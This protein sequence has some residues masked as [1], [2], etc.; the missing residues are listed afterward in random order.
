MATYDQIFREEMQPAL[1]FLLEDA[2]R[3]I[4]ELDIIAS[5]ELIESLTAYFDDNLDIVFDF[6]T[7]GV[8]QDVGLRGFRN[9]VSGFRPIAP[10]RDTT[11][12]DPFAA[13][14]FVTSTPNVAGRG[15]V[16]V[17]ARNLIQWDY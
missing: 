6:A 1:D 11:P 7:Q 17:N 8:I 13:G 4:I 9:P 10:F 16:I 15:E 2:E 12:A 3:M 14:A 5:R